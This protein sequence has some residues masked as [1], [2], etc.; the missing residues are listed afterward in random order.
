MVKR[1]NSKNAQWAWQLPGWPAFTWRQDE[2]TPA[3]VSAHRALGE[4]SSDIY[5]SA[6]DDAAI[7]LIV[8]DAVT[9]SEIEGEKPDVNRLRSSVARRMGLPTAGMPEPGPQEDGLVAML[10]DATRNYDQPLTV[11]R[12]CQWQAGLF[13]QGEWSLRRIKVGSLRGKKPMQIVSG[14]IGKERIHFEAPPQ[15]R[16][17][18]ELKAFLNWF[19]APLSSSAADGLIRAGIAHLWFE[20]LHPFEDGNGRVGRAITDMALAQHEGRGDRRFSLSAQILRERVGYYAALEAA[21]SARSKLDITDWLLWFIP[22]VTE[23]A[24]QGRQTLATT[25]TKARYWMRFK[26]AP[27]AERQR[28]ILNRLLDAGSGGFEGGMTTRKYASLTDVGRVTASQELTALSEAGC[29]V[30]MGGGRSTHYDIPWDLF[31][32]KGQNRELPKP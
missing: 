15:E 13:Q 29:L 7:S 8:Q 2:L 30:S 10:L 1:L 9:T 19:N 25:V 6:E 17:P 22:Q 18:R 12:L 16:L 26:D 28:K 4:L 21:S 11:K 24:K 20:V 3:L 27:I 31:Q 32:S 14:P 23:A 5:W